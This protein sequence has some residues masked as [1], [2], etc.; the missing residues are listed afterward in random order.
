MEN[1]IDWKEILIDLGT[2]FGIPENIK[3][4]WISTHK[5]GH[6]LPFIDLEDLYD[7]MKHLVKWRE[8]H[9]CVYSSPE[10]KNEK[11]DFEYFAIE[12]EL[13]LKPKMTN[14]PKDMH[15]IGIKIKIGMRFL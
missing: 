6:W 12:Q 3:S 1:E 15:T 7:S 10:H 5:F 11:R 9:C 13:I 4:D 2:S 14:L 8:F